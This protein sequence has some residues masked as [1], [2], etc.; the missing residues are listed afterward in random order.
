[1]LGGMLS[2]KIFHN[3][4]R[5]VQL[6]P[7]YAFNVTSNPASQRQIRLYVIGCRPCQGQIQ[8]RLLSTVSPKSNGRIRSMTKTALK[9]S[10]MVLGAGVT[11]SVGY[12]YLAHQRSEEIR[13]RWEITREEVDRELRHAKDIPL[14]DLVPRAF[15]LVLIFSPVGALAIPAYYFEWMREFWYSLL[16]KTL[17][18]SGAAFIKWGQWAATRPD[19]FPKEM[20]DHLKALHASVPPHSFEHTRQVLMDAFDAPNLEAIFAEID[21]HPIGS[22]SIAQVYKARFHGDKEYVAIKVRHPEVEGR[23]LLDFALLNAAASL[24]NYVPGIQWMGIQE[25]LVQF[26]HTLGAQVRLDFEA[27][28]LERFKTNFRACPHITASFPIPRDG[29]HASPEILIESFESGHSVASY[30]V[31]A[32][33]A[34]AER[35]AKAANLTQ[36][37]TVNLPP[38]KFVRRVSGNFPEKTP[39]LTELVVEQV[40][41]HELQP[42]AQQHATHVVQTGKETYLQMLLA[43]N[44]IHADMH[45][46]NII[47]K[48][49]SGE[50]PTLVLIDAGMVDVMTSSEQ[51]NF[52][53][54]FKAMGA[55]DGLRA[56]THLLNFAHEQPYADVEGFRIYMDSLF[57]K[58]CRGFG[59]NV[60]L[61]DV[62]QGVLEGLRRHK[63]RVDAQY[64]TSVVNLL[65]I[66]SIAS[67]LDPNYNLLDE[68][69]MLLYAH[70]ILGKESMAMIL[71]LT[72]PSITWYRS[73]IYLHKQMEETWQKVR[74]TIFPAVLL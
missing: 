56:A 7:G 33:T 59:T 28:N 30:C 44:F 39:D 46:G 60:D 9:A 15:Q 31:A 26:G 49:K 52:I 45:P 71:A 63:V 5:T 12:A 32:V 17:E 47:L 54:L 10:L 48:E 16:R 21:D 34:A 58:K 36:S 72:A 1:M 22:G 8:R 53:G 51:D 64:A 38:R 11:Y 25:T 35:A 70:S 2:S 24:L 6:F 40:T 29:L 43:D 57:K 27:I 74:R 73:A 41:K 18:L 19:I 67:A 20:C 42:L 37:D 23:L 66:E 65:C 68:S 13:R 4:P 55:G 3:A 14:I 61:G 50:P 69:E 62:L